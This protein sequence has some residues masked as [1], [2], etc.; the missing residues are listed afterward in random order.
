MSDI[1]LDVLKAARDLNQ[2]RFINA[3]ASG[4]TQ[5][6]SQSFKR[7]AYALSQIEQYKQEGENK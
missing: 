1:P 5:M 3:I 2:E 6:A 4:D 7:M